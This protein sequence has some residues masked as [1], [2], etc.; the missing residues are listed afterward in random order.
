MSDLCIEPQTVARR[1]AM[2]SQD[3]S[4]LTPTDWI[5]LDFSDGRRTFGELVKLL[6]IPASKLSESYVHLRL[7]GLLTWNRRE[8]AAGISRFGESKLSMSW[9]GESAAPVLSKDAPISSDDA[10][11]PRFTGY[12][13]EVCSKYIPERYFDAFRRYSPKLFD[14]K[15]DLPVE[16]QVFVEFMYDHLSELTPCEL[17][18]LR[19][20]TS[21]KSEIRQAYMLRTRQFH[22]DRYFRKNLGCFGPRITAIFKAVST[23]FSTLNAQV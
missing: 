20:G 1:S 7:L 21:D 23:A 6:P 3:F 13:D 10:S 15:L 2:K 5:A 11:S 17:L 16:V 18:G 8:D 9:L 12:T 14:A 19:E 22:P 4:L